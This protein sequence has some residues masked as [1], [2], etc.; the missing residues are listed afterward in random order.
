[1]DWG[2]GWKRAARRRGEWQKGVGG[3][4]RRYKGLPLCTS[5]FYLLFEMARRE[6]KRRAGEEETARGWHGRMADGGFQCCTLH[7]ALHP[8]ARFPIF[9]PH[10][11][12]PSLPPP[13]IARVAILDALRRPGEQDSCGE[14]EL[15]L[16]MN[17][18][19]NELSTNQSA[20]T[21]E[22]PSQPSPSSA[23]RGRYASPLVPF[24]VRL[25]A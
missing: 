6:R 23:C 21:L 3:G 7:P 16:E 15:N 19:S 5:S 25:L 8:A 13:F 12:P 4:G 17:I 2:E 10:Q 14:I 11:L 1:M 22:P 20:T 24:S 9:L 18:E